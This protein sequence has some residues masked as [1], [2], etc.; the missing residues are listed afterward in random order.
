M[1]SVTTFSDPPLFRMDYKIKGVQRD[2][3]DL[4]SKELEMEEALFELYESL[5]RNTE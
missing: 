2:D 4:M 3:R 1:T 5:P